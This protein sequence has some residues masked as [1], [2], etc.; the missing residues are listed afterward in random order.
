MIPGG[1]NMAITKPAGAWTYADLFALTDDGRRY[2]IMEGK[3]YDMPVPPWAHA[4]VT[5][6]LISA[7]I[8]LVVML[9]GRWR[10]APLDVFFRELIRCNQI[11][12]SSCL[13]ARL[14]RPNV[15]WKGHLISS[16]K[17]LAPRTAGT[18]C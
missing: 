5:A 3:L 9:G 1:C 2:E 4:T 14:I 11:S 18:T 7:I 15:V 10:T 16:L 8:P 6:N 12:S 17:C 13:K